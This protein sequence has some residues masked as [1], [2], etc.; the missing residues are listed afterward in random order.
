MEPRGRA[1]SPPFAGFPAVAPPY[2][3]FHACVCGTPPW[4]RKV[5][6]RNPR[7]RKRK[8]TKKARGGKTGALKT[9]LT[10]CTHPH[11]PNSHS[12]RRRN[13]SRPRI[14]YNINKNH[15]K[16]KSRRDSL[17]RRIKLRGGG[18]A[19]SKAYRRSM[20]THTVA[21]RMKMKLITKYPLTKS[22]LT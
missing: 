18:A 6:R 12:S 16:E 19:G 9:R 17:V 11:S 4:Q 10:C 20:H 5:R 7:G 22:T 13:H 1:P 15:K 3:H 21:H 8:R 2:R 14:S